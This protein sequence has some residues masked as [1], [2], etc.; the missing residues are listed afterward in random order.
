MS[1]QP[2]DEN[3][4]FVLYPTILKRIHEDKEGRE[5]LKLLASDPTVGNVELA[6]WLDA[7][8]A[9]TIATT[10]TGGSVEKIVN[11]ARADVVQLLPQQSLER[12]KQLIAAASDFVNRESPI[13]IITEAVRAATPTTSPLIF[14]FSGTGGVGKSALAVHV[15][16]RLSDRYPDAQLYMNLTAADGTSIDPGD[17]LDGFLR[18]LGF[19][20]SRIPTRTDDRARAYRTAL[21]SERA[22]ILLD[23]AA[24]ESQIR[25]LLPGNPQSLVFITSRDRLPTV[26]G[27][28]SISLDALEPASALQLLN[29]IVGGSRISA[30]EDA[31]Q[32]VVSLCAHLPL[33]IRVAGAKLVSRPHWGVARLADRLRDESRRLSELSVGDLD[34]RGTFMLSYDGLSSEHQ[35]AFRRASAVA[36]PDFTSWSLAALLDCEVERAEQLAEDL[37]AAQLLETPTED[38]TGEVRY[39]FH[40]LLRVFAREQ[41]TKSESADE[42][43]AA[44]ERALGATL[45][46][47]KRGLFLLSPHSRRDNVETKATLWRVPQDVAERT[48]RRPY[49]WFDAEYSCL[50]ASIRQA[51]KEKL[52]ECAW[53]LTETLHYFFRVRALRKDWEETHKLALEAAQRAGN[54]RGEAWTLRNLGNAYR[55]QHKSAQAAQCFSRALTLFSELG[56]RL[57]VAA[58]LNNLGELSMDSGRLNEAIGYFA[59]CLPAWTDVNDQVG[60]AYVTNHLGVIHR[61]QGKWR[62]ADEFFTRSLAMFRE[63]ADIWGEAHGLRSVADLRRD[64]RRLEEATELVLRA[65]PVFIKMGDRVGEAWTLVTLAHIRLDQGRVSDSLGLIASA[66]EVFRDFQDHR[67]ETWSLLLYGDIRRT[68]GRLVA[69]AAALEESLISFRSLADELGEAITCHLLG[70]VYL[71]QHDADRGREYLA[72]AEQ[73]FR[74]I[75]A[76]AWQRKAGSF[77][78]GLE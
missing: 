68:E 25:P 12:P 57:G 29:K 1:E 3:D 21:A 60:V 18:S 71:A 45:S 54:I 66:I 55:D 51:H 69:A 42:C 61:Q 46:L 65:R 30:E 35:R 63:L 6:R 23:N 49:D 28:I 73:I 47:A 41:L 5:L 70:E 53:E 64:E 17:A 48:Q 76:A 34:V 13:R 74:Q 62:D 77:L 19:D 78:A 72:T 38:A 2:P 8:G 36:G 15:A 39:R 9:S 52:W 10:V 56:N 50:I 16:H 40:D 43:H 59:K 67:G 14:I 4:L 27:A 37:V 33:A 44:V 58:A 24:T 7:Q 32:Q 22:I 31:A 20:G 75:G 26:V 11:I